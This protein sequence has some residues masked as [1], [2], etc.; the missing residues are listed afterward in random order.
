LFAIIPTTRQSEGQ[1]PIEKINIATPIV[2]IFPSEKKN[3]YLFVH[4]QETICMAASSIGLTSENC[5]I[6]FMMSLG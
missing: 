4:Q 3:W 2:F 6:P 1:T 5:E